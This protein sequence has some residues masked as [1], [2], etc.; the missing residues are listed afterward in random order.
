MIVRKFMTD[1]LE[2]TKKLAE[3]I[4]YYDAMVDFTD[5]SHWYNPFYNKTKVTVI[6]IDDINSQK[7]Y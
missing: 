5:E 6:W 3:K 2:Y 1:L 4:A 7:R